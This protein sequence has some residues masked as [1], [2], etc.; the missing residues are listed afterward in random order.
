MTRCCAGTLSVALLQTHV[1]QDEKFAAEHMP[2][3][4]AWVA[5]QLLAAGYRVRGTVRSTADTA[6]TAHL[7]A[8]PIPCVPRAIVPS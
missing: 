2:E 1:K 8:M 4:L 7:A 5:Q 6:K 3:T